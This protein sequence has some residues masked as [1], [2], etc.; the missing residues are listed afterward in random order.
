MEIDCFG[1]RSLPF[2]L[3][4]CLMTKVLRGTFSIVDFEVLCG[5][6]S[7]GILILTQRN[8]S[9]FLCLHIKIFTSSVVKRFKDCNTKLDHAELLSSSVL[10]AISESSRTV[11]FTA[12][13][14]DLRRR[15]K[16]YQSGC[17]Q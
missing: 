2:Y 4:L 7:G 8:L 11:S 12:N 15:E 16:I 1:S 13:V 17:R 14:P 6:C 3:L 10:C 5:A 9:R